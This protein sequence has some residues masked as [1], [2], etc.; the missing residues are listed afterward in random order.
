MERSSVLCKKNAY[1]LSHVAAIARVV[2][3]M[4]QQRRW[5][6]KEWNYEEKAWLNFLSGNFLSHLS[7]AL[8]GTE[9][10]FHQPQQW[11]IWIF[12]QNLRNQF[13]LWGAPRKLISSS[14]AVNA[15]KLVMRF[16]Q[17]QS[18]PSLL[19]ARA[20]KL[21]SQM[22]RTRFNIVYIN[23]SSNCGAWLFFQ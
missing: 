2:G 8:E 11:S 9:H 17:P 18:P 16:S 10:I 20:G 4:A 23:W 13:N 22:R 1:F 7:P 12:N 19:C 15:K 21:R 14:F 3:E 5:R 6:S